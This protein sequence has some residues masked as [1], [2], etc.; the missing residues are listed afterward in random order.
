MMYSYITSLDCT[1]A[2]GCLSCE[3]KVLSTEGFESW[4]WSFALGGSGGDPADQG[5]IL[6]S[7]EK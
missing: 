5:E 6:D 7:V 1:R 2:D 4:G 3:G